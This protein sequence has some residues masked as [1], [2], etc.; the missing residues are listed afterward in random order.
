MSRK[1]RGGINQDGEDAFSA[2]C[3]A[4]GL[5]SY[6][7][8]YEVETPRINGKYWDA[9]ASA[10]FSLFEIME[11][12]TSDL[13]NKIDQ[14]KEEVKKAAKRKDFFGICKIDSANQKLDD[15]VEV[16]GEDHDTVKGMIGREF[17]KK[18]LQSES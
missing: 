7:N 16:D 6:E 15:A 11:A 14:K 8:W 10:A 13:W 4:S 2:Y 17:D 1:R 3:K 18:N 12:L 9:V 5:K